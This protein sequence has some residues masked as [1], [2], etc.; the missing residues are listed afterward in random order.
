MTRPASAT[1]QRPRISVC[2]GTHCYVLGGAE[3]LDDVEQAIDAGTLPARLIGTTCMGHCS[4]PP[5][6]GGAREARA[7]WTE[8]A[9]V[10]IGDATADRIHAA[11]AAAIGAAGGPDAGVPAREEPHATT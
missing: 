1:P 2:V 4:S 5:P 7:P 11:V 6:A 3:L 10:P 9:G 8:V